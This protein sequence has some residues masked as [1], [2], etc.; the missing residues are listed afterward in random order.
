MGLD[1]SHDAFHGAYS[2]F[3]RFRQVVCEATGGEWPDTMALD[4]H[5]YWTFGNDY[6]NDSHPGLYA[7]FCHSDCDGEIVPELCAKIADEMEALLPALD[8]QGLG[9]GHIERVGG[10]GAVARRF[11]AGCREAHAA[12]EALEFG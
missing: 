11:I 8:A 12:N 7:F 3:N 10:Y 5:G 6:T 9:G 1:V 2:A 4:G